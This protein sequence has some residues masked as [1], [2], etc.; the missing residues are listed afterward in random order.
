MKISAHIQ[1]REGQH[2][3]GEDAIRS[4]AAETDRLAEIQNTLRTATPVT[5]SKVEVVAV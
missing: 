1:N 3:A 5:L 4:L 2:Q